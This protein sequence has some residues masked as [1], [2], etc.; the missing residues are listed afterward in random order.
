MTVESK[1]YA[2]LSLALRGW[3]APQ[4][5][6]N[7][8]APGMSDV[9]YTSDRTAGWIELKQ[10]KLVKDTVTLGHELTQDQ[11]HFLRR[12]HPYMHA[13]VLIGVHQDSTWRLFVIVPADRTHALVG[14]RRFDLQWLLD[15]S[16]VSYN[17]K[18]LADLRELI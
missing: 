2:R 13:S 14:L 3:W 18:N 6:E 4:R 12:V 16:A 8:L 7:R 10:G 9:F 5:L 17:P 1:L 11:H 15:L